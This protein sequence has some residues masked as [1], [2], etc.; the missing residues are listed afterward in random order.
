[1]AGSPEAIKSSDLERYKLEFADFLVTSQQLT[2]EQMPIGE[3]K[4]CEQ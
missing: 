4:S 3:G 2:L 1:M